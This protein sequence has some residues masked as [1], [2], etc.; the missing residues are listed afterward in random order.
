MQ[1][2][3]Q[4]YKKLNRARRQK[5]DLDNNRIPVILIRCTTQACHKLS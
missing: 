1:V 4:Q 3:L 2:S 5:A